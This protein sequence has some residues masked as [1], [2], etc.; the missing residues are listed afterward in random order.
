MYRPFPKNQ[1]AEKL[2]GRKA[3]GVIDRDVSFGWNCGH[4]F[5]EA[6][7]A[8]NDLEGKRIPILNF[9]GG[10]NGG[11]ITLEHMRRAIDDVN[12]AARGKEYQN[13]TFFELG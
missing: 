10:L 13:V 7:A 12:M 5:V 1:L 11:D 4:L 2:K 6:K 9:I 8:L 3:I